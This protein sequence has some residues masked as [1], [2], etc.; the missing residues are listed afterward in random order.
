MSTVKRQALNLVTVRYLVVAIVL[1]CGCQQKM[2]DQPSFGV[3]AP[4]E[5]FSEGRSARPRVQGT[6]ARGYLHANAALFTGR[7]TKGPKSDEVEKKSEERSDPRAAFDG[8][9]AFVAAFLR[10][11]DAPFIEHG[12]DR[13]A[14]F[15]APCHDA[16]GT[17]RGPIVERGYTAPPSFHNDRLRTAP[18][19]RLFA[20]I[21]EGY[22][23]MPSYA[24]QVS[25]EDRWA[26][27]AFVRALQMS[28]HWPVAS[29]EGLPPDKVA[30]AGGLQRRAVVG[31]LR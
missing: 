29:L 3:Y 28:Q 13:Y 21:S 31:G 22:G 20:V 26:I 4:C 12:R 15:C 9:G 7:L 11:I 19:G 8:K 10:P 17:G 5:F 23:S 14:I 30:S 25:C 2:A 6:V 24:E 18:P 16:Q 27:V 1:P